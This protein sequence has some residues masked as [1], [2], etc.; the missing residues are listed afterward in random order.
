MKALSMRKY[1]ILSLVLIGASAV[2]AAVLPKNEPR[3]IG[4]GQLVA[5]AG[6]H[7]TVQKTCKQASGVNQCTFTATGNVAGQGSRTTVAGGTSSITTAGGI[8]KVKTISDN[9]QLNSSQS[10]N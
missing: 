6:P 1:S 3:K 8:N 10:P 5:S 9:G 4:P 7:G 2:T